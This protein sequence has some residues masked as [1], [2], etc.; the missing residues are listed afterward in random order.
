MPKDNTTSVIVRLPPTKFWVTQIEKCKIHKCEQEIHRLRTNPDTRLAHPAECRANPEGKLI[1]H[2]ET[3]IRI[4]KELEK[5]I[6]GIERP[7]TINPTRFN[8]T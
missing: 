7:P 1:L 6:K 2:P 4:L 3:K 5:R 8:R